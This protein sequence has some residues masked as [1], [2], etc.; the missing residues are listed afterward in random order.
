MI[1]K[2]S[3]EIMEWNQIPLGV[4]HTNCYVIHTEKEAIII[5]PGGNGSKLIDWV[6]DKGLKPMA[7]LLTHAHFDHIGAVDE[8]AEYYQIPKYVHEKE[9][10]WL[11]NPELNGSL[12]FFPEQPIK[13][14]EADQV[15]EGEGTLQIGSFSFTIFETPGHSPGSVSYY[16]RDE[17]I[18][19]SG[20]VLFQSSIGRTDLPGGNYQQLMETI[21]KKLIGLPAS[22]IVANG[23]GPVTT[24]GR[25]LKNNPFLIRFK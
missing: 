6:E 15:I 21:E 22:T 14:R 7:I 25:E 1:E 4:L 20:D 24:I 8:I 10:N 12:L 13:V 5:D 9:K 18:I 17:D 19:F 23:H 11:T 2:R 16:L 3:V